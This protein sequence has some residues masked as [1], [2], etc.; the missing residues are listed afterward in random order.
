LA[1]KEKPAPNASLG[2]EIIILLLRPTRRD[3]S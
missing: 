1:V 3:R 2:G